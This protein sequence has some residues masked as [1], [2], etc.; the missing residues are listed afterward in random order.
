MK[1][2]WKK[3]ILIVMSIYFVVF[4]I[5]LVFTLEKKYEL[6]GIDN[7]KHSKI[8]YLRDSLEM[9]Y[10]KKYLNNCNDINTGGDYELPR[11]EKVFIN[12]V[13]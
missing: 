9:E 12:T 3:T 5:F 6:Q 13:R 2:Y 10:Y 4:S 11:Q 7:I 8:R 1:D